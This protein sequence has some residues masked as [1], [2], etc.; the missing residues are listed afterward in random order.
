MSIFT[1]AQHWLAQDPDPETHA[2]LTALLDAAKNGGCESKH[3]IK[4]TL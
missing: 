1:L 3:R 4:C 2:E